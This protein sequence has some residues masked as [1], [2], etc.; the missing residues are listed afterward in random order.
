MPLN[1]I[2]LPFNL[3]PHSDHV[4][5]AAFILA[6]K[7]GAEVEC[8]FPQLTATAS[9]AFVTEATPPDM[10][11]RMISDARKAAHTAA[12]HA[13]Q[14]HLR[15]AST[16]AG[17]PCTFL[18]AEGAISDIVAARARLA[19]LTV[20][21]TESAQDRIFWDE[22]IEGALFSSGRPVLL[23][24]FKQPSPRLGERLV[25]AWQDTVEVSRAIAGARPLLDMASK[26]DL[27]SVGG[28]EAAQK[29][30]GDVCAALGRSRA[31][32]A[33]KVLPGEQNVTEALARTAEE[34]EGSI[35]VIGAYSHWRWRERVFGGVTE[36][37]LRGSRV[38]VLM[39][40]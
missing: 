10:V 23:V 18:A 8:F 7:L 12:L 24:P 5:E 29:T 3:K 15:W 33:M 4:A 16:H 31:G 39:V 11:E 6:R 9:M 32:V 21:A 37:I 17:V 22:V 38:P 34:A 36:S 2:L 25:I 40:H 19:D 27:V 30:L 26:V 14:H 20:C 13:K 35:L 1:R 28:D